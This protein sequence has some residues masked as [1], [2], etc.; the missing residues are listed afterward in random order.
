MISD[1]DVYAS[2][3]LLIEKH[4]GEAPIHAAM[5]ADAMLEKDGLDGQ[6]VWMRIIRAIEELLRGR[7]NDPLH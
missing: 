2:A 4:R 1:R 3:R 7:G 6:R 5:N